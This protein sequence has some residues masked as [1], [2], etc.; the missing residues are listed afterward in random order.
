VRDYV[1]SGLPSQR[2]TAVYFLA[3][4]RVPA[5]LSLMDGVWN[6]RDIHVRMAIASTFWKFGPQPK[7]FQAYRAIMRNTP[8]PTDDL[9]RKVHGFAI[10]GLARLGDPEA[11][12][13]LRKWAIAPP[14]YEPDRPVQRYQAYRNSWVTVLAQ[15]ELARRKIEW[16]SRKL[17][18]L[19]MSDPKTLPTS[20]PASRPLTSR[21]PP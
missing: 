4:S 16:P 14:G 1:I 2:A 18:D 8:A 20:A 15:R 3:N 11:N 19:M 6:D 13:Y 5:A 12:D 21:P 10:L 17:Y 7:V 9:V